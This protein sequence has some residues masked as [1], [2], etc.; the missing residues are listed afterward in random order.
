MIGTTYSP[1]WHTPQVRQPA[2]RSIQRKGVAQTGRGSGDGSAVLAGSDVAVL[3][4]T[5]VPGVGNAVVS[6]D[7]VGAAARPLDVLAATAADAVD[8]DDTRGNDVVEES[9]G[10][11]VLGTALAS[12]VTAL[13]EVGVGETT[14]ADVG[15]IDGPAVVGWIVGEIV[16][17]VRVLVI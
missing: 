8:D 11:G 16:E 6:A 4:S 3:A 2:P 5:V 9:G 14:A 15:W 13:V 17:T 10:F 7:D 12:L 1:A